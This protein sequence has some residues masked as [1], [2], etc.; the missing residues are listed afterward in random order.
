MGL[1]LVNERN[2]FAAGCAHFVP[3]VHQGDTC[4]DPVISKRIGSGKPGYPITE[5]IT[6]ASSAQ[7][8]DPLLISVKA[9]D[10]HVY[11]FYGEVQ[12]NPARPL[13][14][15][16]DAHSV[17]VS[18]DLL[19]RL[20]VRTGDTLRIGGQEFRIAGVVT[21]EPDRMT[22]TLNV[23]PRVMI[24]REGLDRTGLIRIGSRASERFLF[25]LPTTGAPDVAEVR[26]IRPRIWPNLRIIELGDELLGRGGELGAAAV[27][28]Y[29]HVIERRPEV[30]QAMIQMGRGREVSAAKAED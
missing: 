15:V 22:G 23:G 29:R 27:G 4:H 3:P 10:P 2:T 21:S 5:T 24:A 13:G 30:G 9:I 17:V 19:L 12:L 1:G 16:L 18:D 11:P 7:T 28:R 14:E 6:M 8:P 25:H 20:N 26:R